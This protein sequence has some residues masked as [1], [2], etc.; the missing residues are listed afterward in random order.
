MIVVDTSV[1]VDFFNGVETAE[2][3]RLDELLG[4]EPLAIG[5]LILTEILQGFR[6][7]SAYRQAR[8]LL[9]SLTIFEMLGIERA[10]QSASNFR[11]LRKL[12]LTVRK[13]AD[14][15]IASSCISEGH[16]L[17]FSD[18]DFLPFVEHLGLERA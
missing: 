14:I 8:E 15:I 3:N 11:R 12:G 10:L 2:S 16:Q 5:D 13:T 1:W 4:R 17:L 18:K 6:R 9:L 7:D